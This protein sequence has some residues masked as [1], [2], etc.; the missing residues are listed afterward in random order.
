MEEKKDAKKLFGA[1]RS[2]EPKKPAE[3][4]FGVSRSK[5]PK[6]LQKII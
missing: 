5:D 6:K 1:R 2:K 3:S 4:C